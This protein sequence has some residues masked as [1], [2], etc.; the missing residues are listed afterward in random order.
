MPLRDLLGVV[1][2]TEKPEKSAIEQTAALARGY[3]A[4]PTVV[5]AAPKISTPYTLFKT[6]TISGLTKAEN[7]KLNAR[8]AALVS[9]AEKVILGAG[10]GGE[11]HLCAESFRELLAEVKGRA[12]CADLVVFDR[13]GGPV[14]RSEVLFEEVLF[15]T[16]RPV[17]LAVPGRKPAE[18]FNQ[19]V[20]A[21]DGSP[22]AA[23]ALGVALGL[24]AGIGEAEV[25]T[26]SG[27]KNLADQVPGD[28]IAAHIGRHGAKAKAVALKVE[29]GSVAAT[30]DAHAGRTGADLIVM[31]GFG[32]SRLRE[33]VLGGVTR[34]LTQRARVSLLLAH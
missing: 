11:V 9:E 7:E 32:H 5:V 21:W 23:R 3:G 6:Q 26:V 18:K 20:L 15:G 33:F 8:A 14:E 2:A 34:D 30:I 16:G 19:I 10:K 22:H 13:P 28:K 4:Q 1:E 12:L 29:Q 25:I 17:L 31:G 27:E 24:F